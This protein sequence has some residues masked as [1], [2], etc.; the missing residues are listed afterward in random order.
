MFRFVI[1]WLLLVGLTACNGA[2]TA[3]NQ[4]VVLPTDTAVALTPTIPT[5]SVSPAASSTSSTDMI[6]ALAVLS[7]IC[8]EA[9]H[10]AVGQVFVLRNEADLINL[11]D[12]ADNARLCSQPVDRYGFD[13]SNDTILVGLWSRGMGCTARHEVVHYRRDAATISIDLRFI[14]VGDCPYELVRPFWVG[15]P[16]AQAHEVQIS[17]EQTADD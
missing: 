1:V 16:Q 5:V 13:F 10:D 7:G 3:T 6:D 11:Y 17:V 15:L 12:L 14:T 9:A 4:I 8:F 2:S